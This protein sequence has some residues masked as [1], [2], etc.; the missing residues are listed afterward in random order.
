MTWK[1]EILKIIDIRIRNFT[2]NPHL[3]KQ[4]QTHSILAIKGKMEKFQRKYVFVPADK[5][6]NN[7][8]IV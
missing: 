4:P 8:I 2:D 3:Y 5:A 7:I 6:A 1:K